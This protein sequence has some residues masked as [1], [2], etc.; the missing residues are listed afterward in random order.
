MAAT[1]DPQVQR[2]IEVLGPLGV[3]AR[4]MFG[5]YGLYFGDKFFGIVNDGRV[6]FRTDEDSRPEY[7]ARGMPPFQ[8]NNRPI[9]PK[10]VARNFQ[11]PDEVLTDSELLVEWA[12][13]AATS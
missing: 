11:V 4:A 5:G 12:L 7:I 10:T 8:P 6:F 2:L 1:P 3:R 13:R 9:G